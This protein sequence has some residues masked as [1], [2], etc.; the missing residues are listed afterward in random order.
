MP[1]PASHIVNVLPRVIDGGSQNLELNGLLLSEN[2]IISASTMVLGFPTARAVGDYFGIE[3]AEYEA[4]VTYFTGYDNKFAAP[5]EFF[6]ARRVDAPISGWLRSARNAHTLE[7]YKAITDGG[8]VI[9]ING[10][11]VTI[12]GIDLS[13]ANSFSEVAQTIQAELL[14]AGSPGALMTYSSLNNTFTITSGSVGADSA[15]GYAAAPA[16]GTDLASFIGLREQDGAVISP[17]MDTMNVNEQMDAIRRVTENWV[18]FTTS[19]EA[20]SAEMLEWAAWA[21]D[22]YGWLYVAYTTNPTTVSPDSTVDPASVL[23]NSEN[24]HTCIIYGPLDYAC[25]IM[26]IVASIAWTR[27]NGAITAAFKRQSGLAPWVVDEATAAVLEGKNCNYVGNFAT[28]NAEFVFLYPGCMSDSEYRFIDPY[29]NSI[30]LNNRLQ[31]SLMDGLT[32]TGRPPYNPRG[33]TM[34]RAWMRQPVNEGLINGVIEPG[35]VLSEIQK[36]ELFN[37]AGLDIS[38]NLWTDGYYIQVL[39]PGP[40]VRAERG[41]PIVSIW[42]TY[43]GAIQKIEVASTAIL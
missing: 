43:G 26:G 38:D 10:N 39:D 19:W 31:V 35:V 1:I 18:S 20:D 3:S 16:T 29:V 40:S 30:W 13:S 5:R 42:Y 15:V 28:R 23:A 7:Q 36:S 24:D 8:F 21:N 22:N 11:A 6:I 2:P 27:I 17:G 41:S 25:F 4:A 37:E 9:E 34:V 14:G 12:S 33:Y 32:Q